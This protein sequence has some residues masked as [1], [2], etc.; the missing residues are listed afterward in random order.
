[1]GMSMV[2]QESRRIRWRCRR[3]LLELDCVLLQFYEQHFDTLDHESRR[4]FIRLLNQPDNDILAWLQKRE[5]P[6]ENDLKLIV[7]KIYN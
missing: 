3:G 6:P 1:M 7:D 2:E 4:A 5:S